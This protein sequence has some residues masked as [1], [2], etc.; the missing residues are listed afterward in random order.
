M[1]EVLDLLSDRRRSIRDA[2]LEYVGGSSGLTK[3]AEAFVM[4]AG[5]PAETEDRLLRA[6]EMRARLLTSVM[7]VPEQMRFWR[8]NRL[9]GIHNPGL[10]DSV[11]VASVVGGGRNRR[12]LRRYGM[13]GSQSCRRRAR[14]L[15]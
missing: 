5:R 13:T 14:A 8:G 3:I 11:V 12:P 6:L 10:R 2:A 9:F 7:G 4:T 15:D 1:E